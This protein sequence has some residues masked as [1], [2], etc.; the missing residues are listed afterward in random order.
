MQRTVVLKM[1]QFVLISKH[2]ES[3][4]Y[5]KKCVVTE[6]IRAAFFAVPKGGS[7]A[8]GQTQKVDGCSEWSTYLY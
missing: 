2:C 3:L 8:R 7:R 6:G 1:R 5:M 4:T